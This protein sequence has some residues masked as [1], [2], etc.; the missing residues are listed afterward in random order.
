MPNIILYSKDVIDFSKLKSFEYDN[1]TITAY[2]KL[3]DM[4]W[5]V[6][7]NYDFEMYKPEKNIYNNEEVFTHIIKKGVCLENL[8]NICNVFGEYINDKNADIDVEG[9]GKG[10]LIKIIKKNIEGLS[11]GQSITFDKK[12]TL[13]CY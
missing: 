10:N 12:S 3:N 8:L 5:F 11:S 2:G 7:G 9:V 1:F 4:W 13:Y 6:Y